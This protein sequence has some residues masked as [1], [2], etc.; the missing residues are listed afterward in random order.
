[1]NQARP[2]PNQATP[3][4]VATEFCVPR[5]GILK[6]SSFFRKESRQTTSKVQHRELAEQAKLTVLDVQQR[7]EE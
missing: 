5:D 3:G 4:D 2:G 6:S 7:G 1:M